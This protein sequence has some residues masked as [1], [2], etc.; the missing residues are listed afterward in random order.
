MFLPYKTDAPIYH[1]PFG[2]VGLI[3]VNTVLFF[4][5]MT[6]PDPYA[7]ME[8]WALWYGDGLHPVQ[9]LSANFMH[10]SFSHLFGNMFALW[11]FGIIV[12]GKI[13][14]WRFLLI[15][16]GMGIAQCALEQVLVPGTM[17]NASLGASGVIFGLMAMALVWAPMNEVGC[18]VF[19][20]FRPVLFDLNIIAYCALM[21]S[22][23][24]IFALLSGMSYGS[25]ALHLIGA[26]FGLGVGVAML[27]LD[28]VDCENW[29]LFSVWAGRNQ[30]SFEERDALRE[31][32]PIRVDYAEQRREAA[33][34]QHREAALEQVRLTIAEGR[35]KLAHTAHRKMAET[36]TNWRLPEEDFRKMIAG[37]HRAGEYIESVPL[38]I[39]YLR[40]YTERA[41]LVRLKLAEILARHARQP[42]QARR[43]LAS[44]PRGSL[45][46][47]HA[48]LFAQL[49][50][51]TANSLQT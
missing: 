41:P 48:N 32:I 16:L 12:E 31:S 13:G 46:A 33:L 17:A 40:H 6:Q 21:G 15:Y 18:F 30:M 22:L 5:I 34:E 20:W 45:D 42:A 43:V 11:G 19:I 8:P 37:Y 3:A 36:H 29:D 51:E 27:K 50:R 10:I 26:L 24:F 4:H 9:W 23:Q 44:I 2:T 1:W 25:E 7:A 35:Y 47:A 49:D 14:W 39:E 38:M 28:W